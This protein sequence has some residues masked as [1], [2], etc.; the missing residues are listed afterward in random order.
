MHFD[1]SDAS[2][3]SGDSSTAAHGNATFAGNAQLDTAQS[4]FG[5]SSLLLDGTGDYLT[6]A[7][8]ADWTFGTSDFTI[9]GFV[10]FASS[11]TTLV[12]PPTAAY[13]AGSEDVN[14]KL[15]CHFDGVDGA[16]ATNDDSTAA[17][18]AATFAGTAQLDTAQF[19]YGS[20][21]LLLDGNSDYITFPD[22]ADWT[23]GN[24]NFT[25]EMFVRFNGAPASST[26]ISH[27]N[28]NGVNQRGWIFNFDTT[29]GLQFSYST[30]GASGTF[31][32]KT[33]AWSPSADTW[34]HVVAQRRGTALN[35]FV[36]GVN[37]GYNDIGTASFFNS[38]TTLM[39]GALTGSSGVAGFFNGW[40]DEV[41]ISSVARFNSQVIC[42]HYLNTGNQRGWSFEKG[43]GAF[44]TFNYSLDGTNVT[45][46]NK[47][48]AAPAFATWYHVA[49][50]RDG[51]TLR[52]FVDGT[53]VGTASIGASDSIFNSTDGLTIGKLFSVTDGDG[54][55]NGW[56][57]DLRIVLSALYHGDFTVPTKA[58]KP[59]PP[60]GKP[61]KPSPTGSRTST[62]QAEYMS[63]PIKKDSTAQSLV[64]MMVQS[65]DGTTPLTGASPTVTLSKN[66]GSFNACSGAV[67]E[68]SGGWYKVAGNATDSNTLGPLALHATATSG[69]NT[70]VCYTVVNYDP[71]DSV[72][73]GL[74]AL[75]NAAAGANGG[76]PTGDAS[77]RVDVSKVAGTSQTAGDLA[78]LIT[79]VEAKT[80]NLPSD[81]ADASDIAAAVALIQ[82]DTDN[83]QTRI[84]AALTADGNMKSDALRINGDANAAATLVASLSGLGLG[85]V[86]TASFT[87]TTTQ[88][89]ADA[90]TFAGVSNIA[91]ASDHFVGR[92]VCFTSGTL[93]GQVTD[94]TD[95]SLQGSNARFT[96]TA[97][98]SAPADNGTFVIF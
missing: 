93:K 37:V 64:F 84:P 13:V 11:T 98:T 23:L 54:Y 32:T 38:T 95:Y 67:T 14:T 34:Y 9:D 27:Y 24:G 44:L 22:H 51:T 48:W 73:A 16:T 18:G 59:N 49:V 10:R 63:Y 25:I 71:Q 96:V 69:D 42:S 62:R 29:N 81:P 77:G 55:F 61:T 92:I 4:K 94:I 85:T 66:G 60:R 58:P 40:I 87:A 28:S 86:D 91:A 70:D 19:K 56:I 90:L 83:I 6:Y 31:V 68:I 78:T 53:Q 57:D 46:V 41:R 39:I 33:A 97:L 82:A 79:A 76:L 88:F 72:R 50:V 65:S 2:T 75:P 17:H 21:S 5:G 8:H 3:T 26:W 89:E 12:C 43:N 1:G 15:L 80:D 20:A 7:D 45:V 74:T 47:S 52:L 30:D 36:D 35:F